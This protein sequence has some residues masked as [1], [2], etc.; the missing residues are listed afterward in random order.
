MTVNFRTSTIMIINV[1]N[2]AGE[3]DSGE[4]VVFSACMISDATASGCLWSSYSLC[5]LQ[6]CTDKKQSSVTVLEIT[7]R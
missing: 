3:G 2:G 5:Y 7:L 6:L 4:A 1:Q